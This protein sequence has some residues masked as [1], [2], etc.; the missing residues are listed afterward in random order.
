MPRNA[1]APL[2]GNDLTETLERLDLATL[3]PHPR[4]DGTHPPDELAHLKASI[5]QH[6]I[7]RNVVVANDGTI[8]AGHGVVQAA[9]A[10][11]QTHI[12]G[13][14]MPYGPDDPQAL[15]LLVGDN[16]I[17]RL[18]MQDD[19]LLAAVLQDVAR[20]DVAAL[21][22]TG[23]DEAALE[24]LVQA[25]GTLGGDGEQAGRDV[26]PQIDRAEELRQAWG[27]E[28][29]QLWG[30][31][32]HRLICGDC[33]DKAVLEQLMQGASVDAVVTDPP[34]GQNQPGV[35]H[36]DPASF[37]ALAYGAASLFPVQ[38]S[39]CAI[40]QSP[41]MFPGWLDA[42]RQAGYD[43]ERM[44]WLYKA[45]QCTYPWRGWLLKSEAILI[46]AAGAPVWQDVHP[47]VHDCYYLPE[48]S[49]E[50]DDR[51]GWH[52]SVKPLSVVTDL[53]QR[54]SPVNG[55]VYDGFLGSGTT[56]IACTNVHRRCFGCE[57]DPGYVAVTL[58]RYQ[59]LTGAMPARVA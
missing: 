51:L 5:T 22:G 12:P 45:A 26:E 59:D 21:L 44:L 48:V 10:L 56:L 58:Q 7:Y 13:Q 1:P 3:R 9:R 30:L 53:V 20:D 29:G 50:L 41:R 18:R 14:R 46:C 40:F 2:P 16:H 49:G 8:L 42:L 19:A 17:A 33:T 4:N 35:P 27:V 43:F 55:T 32:A 57:I 24:A 15:Q 34:Y 38:D 37:L 36:D 52:G 25:Q 54:L 23:F 31:G 11:G 39:L 47:Y 6:G 28:P